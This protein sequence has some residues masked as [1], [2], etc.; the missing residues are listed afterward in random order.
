MIKERTKDVLE[1]KDGL[2][3]QQ[4]ALETEIEEL[5]AQVRAAVVFCSQRSSVRAFCEPPCFMF[6]FW[7]S[8]GFSVS[9][10]VPTVICI[11]ILRYCYRLCCY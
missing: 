9:Q 7:V 5:M 4:K 11:L 8:L 2:T 3:K 1:E 6:E 10:Y